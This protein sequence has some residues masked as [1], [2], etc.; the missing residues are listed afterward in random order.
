[1]L[2]ARS[3]KF[4]TKNLVS[5]LGSKRYTGYKCASFCPGQGKQNKL[6]Y[7]RLTRLLAA[8]TFLLGG[9]LCLGSWSQGDAI[10]SSLLWLTL[11]L[12]TR[13]FYRCFVSL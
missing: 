8:T 13:K 10:F 11:P 2:A 9:V 7:R 4:A 5:H 1:M 3:H 12:V 6:H